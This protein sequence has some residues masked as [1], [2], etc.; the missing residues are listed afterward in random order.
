MYKNAR[1]EGFDFMKK[2]KDSMKKMKGKMGDKFKDVK[3]EIPNGFFS[4]VAKGG[5]NV[6]S[7]FLGPTHNYAKEI[8]SPQEMGMSPTGSMDSMAKNVS[9]IIAYTDVLVSG[10][11]KAQHNSEFKEAC[12]PGSGKNCSPLGNSFYLETA[13]KCKDEKGQLRKR[14][15][16]INNKPTGS[17]PFISDITGKNTPGL[18]G[19]I[20]GAIEN[21]GQINPVS[22]F[23]AFLQGANPKCSKLGLKAT[24]GQNGKYVANA[25]IADLDPCYWDS[26]GNPRKSGSKDNS[27]W[28]KWAPEGKNKKTAGCS[29]KAGFINMNKQMLNSKKQPLYQYELTTKEPIARVYNLVF[30][31]LL[32]YLMYKGMVKSGQL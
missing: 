4:K 30:G 27:G 25:D 2:G 28:N 31:G 10:D 7:S 29:T 14:Y 13:G 21:L 1:M 19:L 32:I 6:G 20:P 24:D 18:R 17:I 26:K 5:S 12:D 9:G 15:M 16:Y 11:S 22:M 8:I 3:P 23:S